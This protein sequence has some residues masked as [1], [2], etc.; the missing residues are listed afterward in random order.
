MRAGA[1]RVDAI[2]GAPIINVAREELPYPDALMLPQAYRLGLQKT[3]DY[4]SFAQNSRCKSPRMSLIGI[5][6]RD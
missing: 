4:L 5:A 6:I 3:V 1:E 2:K